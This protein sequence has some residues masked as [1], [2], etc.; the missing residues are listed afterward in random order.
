MVDD[1]SRLASV[2]LFPFWLIGRTFA[3]LTLISMW[4]WQAFLNGLSKGDAA[5][6]TG[7]ESLLLIWITAL[8]IVVLVS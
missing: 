3:A 6:S 4:A 1:V 7:L 5:D 2:A 8:T